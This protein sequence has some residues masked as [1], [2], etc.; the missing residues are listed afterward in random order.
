MRRGSNMRADSVAPG[1]CARGYIG[2]EEV[3]IFNVDGTLY[4]VQGACT[5]ARG[6]LCEG[7][8][9]GDIVSCPWHGSEFNV[10]TGEVVTGPAERP[11][12]TYRVEVDEASGTITLSG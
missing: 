12:K 4:A 11:L 7:A 1:T 9:W 6:P 3:A 5:H 10:R 8:V 2:K